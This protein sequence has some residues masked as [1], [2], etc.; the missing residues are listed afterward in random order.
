MKFTILVVSPN[1]AVSG[2]FINTS[3][4]KKLTKYQEKI[5][6]SFQVDSGAPVFAVCHKEREPNKN[7]KLTEVRLGHVTQPLCALVPHV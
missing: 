2:V 1:L 5:S 4:F 6:G 7:E 3:H